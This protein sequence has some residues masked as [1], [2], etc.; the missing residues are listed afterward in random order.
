MKKINHSMILANIIGKCDKEIKDPQL[1][2]IFS[3]Y[4]G[5]IA[6]FVLALPN[7]KEIE[8]F[9]SYTCRSFSLKE[10]GIPDSNA[11]FTEGEKQKIKEHLTTK[12]IDDL[13]TN[14]YL[15]IQDLLSKDRLK[16]EIKSEL[17]ETLSKI[18]NERAYN[19]GVRRNP[20]LN[21]IL[22]YLEYKF[23]HFSIEI[24]DQ[25]SDSHMV[26]KFFTKKPIKKP[27]KDDWTL[28]DIWML[29]CN[30]E[31]IRKLN[32]R[33]V[34]DNF[35]IENEFIRI[36][37]EKYEWIFFPRNTGNL[38][39]AI[40]LVACEKRGFIDFQDTYGENLSARI[41][42][43]IIQ[44]T[45]KNPFKT[46]SAYQRKKREDGFQKHGHYFRFMPEMKLDLSF[47]RNF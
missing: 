45:F 10:I 42:N 3:E 18:Y 25:D 23:K 37:N 31:E 13:D 46:D 27:K 7:N 5:S 12:F 33:Y 19:E 11:S 43:T 38:I 26:H 17:K 22:I 40:F 16:K 9:I 20:Y 8:E 34:I 35:L 24:H 2:E 15:Y 41:L 1:A 28:F 32:Y 29:D 44:N 47:L 6:H 4:F 39:L 14:L 36:K 21:R 30:D